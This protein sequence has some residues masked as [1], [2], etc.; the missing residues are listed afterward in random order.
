M[1]LDNLVQNANLFLVVLARI[2]AM[3]SVA[4]LLSS[5]SVPSI[6]R[7]SL[8]FFTAIVIFPWVQTVGYVIPEDGLSYAALLIGEILLGL[9]Q[10]FFL[11]LIYT[12]FQTAG[13]FFAVQMGFGASEVYDPLAQIE[14]PVLGQLLNLVAMFVFLSIRGFQQIFLVNVFESFR[15]LKAMDL[16]TRPDVISTELIRNL[17]LLFERS[18]LISL[19]IF[20]T[21][22]L[23][24][25]TLGLLG[26]AAPQMNLMMMGFPFS[27]T[28]G[29]LLMIASLPF[30]VEAFSGIVNLG[31]YE[32]INL[33]GGNT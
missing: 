2:L 9:L 11:V 25:I 27:I 18:F 14:I 13:Q 19:P 10:G 16:V 12:A 1:F 15:T 4:P 22:L 30:L 26:K 28:I 7:I 24:S 33:M 23:V 8:A 3:L 17:S 20:G 6:A 32:L 29:F 21:L 5:D 31:F